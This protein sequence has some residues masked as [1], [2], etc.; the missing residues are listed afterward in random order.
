MLSL[1][2]KIVALASALIISTTSSVALAYT[3]LDKDY[4]TATTRE[5]LEDLY[6]SDDLN[7]NLKKSI[8]L[9]NKIK[10]P[11]IKYNPDKLK[12]ATDKYS[13][14]L[15]D[16]FIKSTGN[17]TENAG[18]CISGYIYITSGLLNK[19]SQNGYADYNIYGLSAV[20]SVYAHEAGHWYYNDSWTTDEQ[21]ESNA[22]TMKQEQ[23]ADKFALK[24]IENV[25]KFSVGGELIYNFH[26]ATEDGWYNESSTHP[27]N[28]SRFDEAY[29]YIVNSSKERVIFDSN[30]RATNKLLVANKDKSAYYT[31]YPQKQVLNGQTV[32]SYIDRAYYVAGQ[33]AWAI[34]NNC[35]DEKHIIFEDAHKYFNDLPTDVKATAIIARKGNQY[36]IIDWY[37][38]DKAD[39]TEKEYLDNL[40]A[41]FQ[42]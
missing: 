17:K 14:G 25:P 23:R 38:N 11:L 27:D 34:K 9:E 2:K 41:S 3:P 22:I 26:V 20:A 31:V 40:K 13:D 10:A 7:Q 33:V 1:N 36:K 21:T 29:N 15:H 30:T 39:T 19:I 6:N 24:T 4:H 5:E 35:Y 32:A 16:V 28:A 18:K 37:L 42:S 12:K 8:L